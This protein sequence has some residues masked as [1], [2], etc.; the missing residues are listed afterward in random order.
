MQCKLNVMSLT[1]WDKR[2]QDSWGREGGPEGC[3]P[4]AARPEQQGAVRRLQGAAAAELDSCLRA[5]LPESGRIGGA[6]L[7]EKRKTESLKGSFQ[8]NGTSWRS[9]REQAVAAPGLGGKRRAV[10]SCHHF[11][12]SS[13]VSLESRGLES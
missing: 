2:W 13:D 7:G 1:E 8:G 9:N 11:D 6:A 5:G 12:T 4:A 10:R 3:R